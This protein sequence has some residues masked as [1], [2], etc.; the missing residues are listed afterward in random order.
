MH[1]T[2]FVSKLINKFEI[3]AG[4]RISTHF[5]VQYQRNAIA[6]TL[7]SKLVYK[8]GIHLIETQPVNKMAERAFMYYRADEK[9]KKLI[10]QV[11]QLDFLDS[12]KE[13]KA[14]ILDILARGGART[15]LSVF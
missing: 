1:Q 12:Q 11:E 13:N 8:E 9:I 7:A 5:P 3:I 4:D 6:S 14:L 15:S 2:I 10:A